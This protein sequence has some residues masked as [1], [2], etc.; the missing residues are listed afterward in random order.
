MTPLDIQELSQPLIDV[1]IGLENDLMMNIVKQLV[2]HNEIT[3]TAK[4][5][6]KKLSEIGALNKVNLETI[7]NAIGGNKGLLEFILQEAALD[8]IGEIEPALF[9]A[10][11]KG[12]LEGATEPIKST[13]LAKVLKQFQNQAEDNLN[14]VN[15]VMQYKAKQK[16]SYMVS[17]VAELTKK[18]EYLSILNKTTGEAITGAISRQQA[19]RQTIIEF[20]NK[21]IP[22]FV[23]KLG[24]EWSPEGYLNMDIRTTTSNVAHEAQFSRMDDYGSDLIEVSS[25]SGA[26]PKCAKYQGK[27]YSRNGKTKGY[28]KFSTTSF[29]LPDGLLGIN[30]G[31]MIY[32]YFKGIST[33]RFFPENN[34]ENDKKYKESQT[35]REL[36]RDVRKAKR[37]AILLNEIGDKDAFQRASMELKAKEQKLNQY[38]KDKQRPRRKDREQA[39]GFDKSV[40]QKAVQANKKGGN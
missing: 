6:I 40:S 23:D 15:T 22:A 14:L 2:K 11:K 26:R 12:I 25:H 28:P 35:Q 29:G 9:E 5:Q 31:H 37:K 16:Y 38:T 24:R 34:A 30:C 32:P 19:L 18:Q 17:K 21:G 13:K 10:T 27:V 20:N 33:Q 3:D 39:F 1:Y 7:V 4:W 8:S 36:E